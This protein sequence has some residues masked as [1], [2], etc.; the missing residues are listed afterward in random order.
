[1]K[2]R[3]RKN[4]M[5]SFTEEN[6][7]NRKLPYEAVVE[8]REDHRRMTE[9]RQEKSIKHI[10]TKAKTEPRFH[11]ENAKQVKLHQSPKSLPIDDRPS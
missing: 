1:M 3:H 4:E 8:V 2:T 9:P 11:S 10:R 7:V 6:R 5:A